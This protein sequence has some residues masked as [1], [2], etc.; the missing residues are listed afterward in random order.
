MNFR[1]WAPVLGIVCG[2][3]A[4]GALAQ[5]A[6]PVDYIVAVVNSDP[7]TNSEVRTATQRILKELT[8]Q[9]APVPP[10]DELR[11]RVLERLINERAQLQAAA[12][13]GLRVEESAVDQAEQ[14][15]A[16]QNQID[17]AELRRRVALDGINPR[18]FRSQ[19]RDQITLARLP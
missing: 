17:V 4:Q 13:S 2:F 6:Q 7:I 11:R 1:T 10:M 9:R 18:Q 5:S 15:V 8:Q 16:R 19:L 14:A 3:L 12:E